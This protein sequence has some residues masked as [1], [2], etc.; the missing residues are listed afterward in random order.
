MHWSSFDFYPNAIRMA[1]ALPLTP[2]SDDAASTRASRPMLGIGLRLAAIA[3]LGV[4]FA[5][6][7][8]AGEQGVHVAESLFWRQLTGLP[9]VIAWLWM[10][11]DL[12]AIATKHP[13]KHAVRMILGL[14][15]MAL[16]FW[17]MTLLPLAEATTLSFATPIFA[18]FLAALL[19]R[20]QTGIYRWSA[21]LLGFI[22]ILVAI[23]PGSSNIAPFGAMVAI[24]G[25]LITAG[26]TIQLRRMSRTES[27]GAIVFW[28]S[29]CSLL[30]L[31]I[32]MLFFAKAHDP[33]TWSYIAGLSVAGAVAQI[34]L[35][36]ALRH[37]PVAAV[38]TMDYS[39]LIWSIL[40]GW[41]I[42]GNLPGLSVWFGA[43]IIIFAGMTIAW[44]EHYLSRKARLRSQ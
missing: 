44:R 41:F 1:E 43:P 27:T 12:S 8:L 22:G 16:N 32:A 21:V 38:M 42:F 3:A 2:L 31:G 6:V 20:E 4:M 7:K 33:T 17:A 26:V 23:Q 37:A 35:T 9:V 28:F 19:L 5:L 11:N 10:N 24:S 25:A 36:S 13:A 14:S 18:T 40:F 34:L 30:P 29:L 39:A 15:A